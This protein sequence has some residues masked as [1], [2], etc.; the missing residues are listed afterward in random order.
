MRRWRFLVVV[1]VAQLALLLFHLGTQSLW[2]DEVMGFDVARG[3]WDGM[4]A[5]F[6][7]LP[8]Q[9]PLYYLL[10][11]GWLVFGT[12]DTA[13]RLFSVIPA[14]ATV[15]ALYFLVERLRDRDTA[16]V[17]ALLT[18]AAPDLPYYGQGARMDA[19]LGLLT[20]LNSYWFVVSLDTR[21]RPA[22]AWY[23]VTAVCGVYTHL[24]FWFVLL[25]QLVFIVLRD[26]PPRRAAL[27]VAAAQALVALAY[28]PWALLL[29]TRKPEP[30]LWKGAA[31][32]V[33]G[34][35]YTLLR[36]S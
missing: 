21:A 33:F 5:F 26:W 3:S 24:F 12:S 10:L 7:S 16:R 15:W 31:Q 30:Q 35:P 27:Q 1:S 11:R 9:H 25:G 29:V 17:A 34:L 8:E 4:F 23:L 18:A 22:V 28:L 19:L 36:V 6:R 32:V 13:L 20:V 2:L 14:V